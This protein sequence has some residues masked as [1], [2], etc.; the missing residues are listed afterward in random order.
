MAVPEHIRKIERPVNTIVEDSGRDSKYRYS[1]RERGEIIYEGKGNNPKPKNGRVIGHII[2]GVFIKKGDETAKVPTEFSYGAVA[3]AYSFSKDIYHELLE[4]YP[5]R[6]ATT[7]MAIATLKTIKPKIAC[8]R[9]STEYERTFVSVYY[10]GCALSKNSIVDFYKRIGMDSE[11]RRKY[12]QKRLESV[13]EE[14]HIAIDGTL[15][16]DNSGVNDFSSFSRKTRVKGTKDISILYAFNIETGE[17]LCSEVYPGNNIDA[18]TFSSFIRNNSIKKGL[19]VADK[20]FPLKNIEDELKQNKELHFLLPLKR[21]SS[22]IKKHEALSWE[23]AFH[24]GDKGI[25]CKKS[26]TKE[27]RFLYSFKDLRRA[28]IEDRS[29][30]ES[31]ISKENFNKAK[32]DEQKDSF[33]TIVFIS[34]LDL[35]EKEVYKIYMERW[36]LELMFSQYKGDLGLTTTRVQGDYSVIGE[37]FINFISTIL[38]SRMT[39]KADNLGLLDNMSYGELMED[40]SSA[41]R[42]KEFERI[43]PKDNDKG[44]IH[45]LPSVMKE[46]ITLGLAISSKEKKSRGRP[47]KNPQ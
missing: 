40:L 15:R 21:N 18:T 8:N 23:N 39:K 7:I 26:K 16:Q 27:N 2:D 36:L 20:G 33:G 4:I 22:L 30:V 45:T 3:F 46:L 29:F 24:V 10:E 12:Y 19:I 32:Y 44:W 47:K 34:D 31:A 28:S 17:P 9:Y 42:N 14:H 11:K 13:C 25:L 6:D 41:W 43:E 1:V 37:E 5:I 38:T 35:S